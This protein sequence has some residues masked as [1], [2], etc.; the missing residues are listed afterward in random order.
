M[1]ALHSSEMR[2]SQLQRTLPAFNFSKLFLLSI[3]AYNLFVF[4]WWRKSW[5]Q[6]MR[7]FEKEPLREFR[8]EHVHCLRE[9]SDFIV[10]KLLTRVS[11]GCIYLARVR[12]ALMA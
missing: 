9:Q 6:T 5:A 11:H 3:P 7:A 10:R 1:E 12:K 2:E 8:Y 4:S